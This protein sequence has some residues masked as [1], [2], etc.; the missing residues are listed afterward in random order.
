MARVG[1]HGGDVVD[2]PADGVDIHHRA[3]R[4]HHGV[5]AGEEFVEQ[6]QRVRLVLRGTVVVGQPEGAYEI[7]FH[8]G[9]LSGG[10]GC[11][12][13]GQVGVELPRVGGEDAGV[14]SFGQA[15]AKFGLAYACGAD[16]YDEGGH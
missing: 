10:G 6:P 2:A 9:Q 11:R 14:E 13:D 16:K 1:I 12:A 8:A 4:Q 15:Q 5:V 3:A 7:M